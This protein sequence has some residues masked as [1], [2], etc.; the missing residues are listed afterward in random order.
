MSTPAWAAVRMVMETWLGRHEPPNPTPARRNAPPI[1]PSYDMPFTTVATSAP[2]AS[3]ISASS[4]AK[5]IFVARKR[6]AP[7]FVIA[8]SMAPMTT[9]GAACGSIQLAQRS[10]T[11]ALGVGDD[12]EH[13]PVGLLVVAHG[14]PFAGELGVEHHRDR[15]TPGRRPA[16]ARP[17]SAAG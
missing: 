4:F 3:Q 11:E 14:A 17:G 16:I 6:F 8:A 2:K 12:A 9:I 1:R 7:S 15:R 5:L 10:L 13:D